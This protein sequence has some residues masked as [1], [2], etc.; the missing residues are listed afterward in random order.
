MT[1][2]RSK[3]KCPFCAEKITQIDYKN[4]P[5]IKRFISQYGRI[6]PRFYSGVCLNHQKKVANSVKLAREMALV[7]YVR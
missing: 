6:V 5:L 3:K 1:A 4:L 7:P 2:G